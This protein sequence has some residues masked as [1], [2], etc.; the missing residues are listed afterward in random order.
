[1]KS[2]KGNKITLLIFSALVILGCEAEIPNNDVAQPEKFHTLKYEQINHANSDI[3][4]ELHNLSISKSFEL[5]FSGS[6]I[7]PFS[8]EKLKVSIKGFAI[9]NEMGVFEVTDQISK[10]IE[11]F[12]Y[13]LKEDGEINCL[14]TTQH[15]VEKQF[16]GQWSFSAL[17]K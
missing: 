9:K 6:L 14:F 12:T 10:N 4:V 1:M 7:D 17:R 16:E 13:I 3:Y 11:I 8:D 2:M 5:D 15:E